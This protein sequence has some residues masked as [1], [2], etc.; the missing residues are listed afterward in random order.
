MVDKT[1]TVFCVQADI[2]S[3][4]E[5]SKKLSPQYRFLISCPNPSF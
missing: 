1:K 3:L 4:S 5:K 2:K